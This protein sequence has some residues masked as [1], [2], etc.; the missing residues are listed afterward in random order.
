MFLFLWLSWRLSDISKVFSCVSA[1]GKWRSIPSWKGQFKKIK[2]LI[3]WPP[4]PPLTPTHPSDCCPRQL[5]V[6]PPTTTVRMLTDFTCSVVVFWQQCFIISLHHK[7]HNREFIRFLFPFTVL[8]TSLRW[9]CLMPQQRAVRPHWLWRNFQSPPRLWREHKRQE[10]LPER[11]PPPLWRSRWLWGAAV[12]RGR[13]SSP[14]RTWPGEGAALRVGAESGAWRSL[15]RPGSRGGAGPAVPA[16]AADRWCTAACSRRRS[17]D[18][19]SSPS[20]CGA[21]WW[22]RWAS[23]SRRSPGP[24]PDPHPCRKEGRFGSE[25]EKM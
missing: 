16:A 10:P 2:V 11:W 14:C 18:A 7:P 21:P 12:C 13:G 22:E 23:Q 19:G 20:G 8:F 1:S 15:R 17:R 25:S 5:P 24:G 4:P 3:A 6:P 9:V